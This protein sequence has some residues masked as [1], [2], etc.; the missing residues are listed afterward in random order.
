MTLVRHECTSLSGQIERL[1]ATQ[2]SDSETTASEFLI[3]GPANAYLVPT[4]LHVERVADA[5]RNGE[6]LGNAEFG[7]SELS[8]IVATARM[9]NQFCAA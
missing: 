3:C 5:V 6:G 8:S 1:A 9:R 4:H 7:S 2:L